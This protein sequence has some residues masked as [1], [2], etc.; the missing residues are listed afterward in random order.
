MN[1]LQQFLARQRFLLQCPRIRLSIAHQ[2]GGPSFQ[3]PCQ[4]PRAEQYPHYQPVDGQQAEG[5]DHSAGNRVVVA[6]NGVLHRVRQREQNNQVKRIQLRQLALTKD[7][8]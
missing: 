4:P 5:A 6:D 7:A 3:Q 2:H 1:N 8:Q